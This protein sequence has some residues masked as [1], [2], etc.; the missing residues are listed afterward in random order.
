MRTL[1]KSKQTDDDQSTKKMTKIQ[2]KT[3]LPKS[4]ETD[5]NFVPC[6]FQ[7]H[8]V[9]LW[10]QC[11]SFHCLNPSLAPREEQEEEVVTICSESKQ[12]ESYFALL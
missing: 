2:K 11:G 1:K 10:T 8:L 3:K 7:C 5:I 12:R 9:L 6:K 4:N